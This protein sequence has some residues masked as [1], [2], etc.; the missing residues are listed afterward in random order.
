MEYPAHWECLARTRDGV[1]YRIR[2]IRLDDAQRERAFIQGLS[3][4]SRYNRMMGTMREPS[5]DLIEQFVHVDYQHDMAFVAVA[6][7]IEDERIIAVARYAAD[8]GGTTGEFAVAVMDEWQARGIGTTLMRLLFEY[9]R[10]QGFSRLHGSMLSSNDRM[11][12]LAHWL[13]MKTERSPE[14]GTLLE[15]S[16]VI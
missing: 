1:G 15:A 8:P 5:P 3:E 12:D 13:G 6:G 2:P 16:R 9:A 11:I 7:P 10:T 4:R 14:D